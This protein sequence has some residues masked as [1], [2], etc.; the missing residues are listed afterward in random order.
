M[1]RVCIKTC[2]NNSFW[3]I[4]TLVFHI[5]SSNLVFEEGLF[6]LDPHWLFS[7]FVLYIYHVKIKFLHL[8]VSLKSLFTHEDV[9]LKE[10]LPIVDS[11]SLCWDAEEQGWQKKNSELLKKQLKCI[12]LTQT[13]MTKLWKNLNTFSILVYKKCPDRKIFHRFI[14]IQSNKQFPLILLINILKH[15]S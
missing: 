14:I 12:S 11:L 8:K 7:T 9:P 2:L 4:R 6:V 1:N 15:G 3:G 5:L 10:K 13:Q